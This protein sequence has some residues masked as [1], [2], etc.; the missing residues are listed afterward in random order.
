[1]ITR[2]QLASPPA[3]AVL[4]RGELA[5]A[6]PIRR[7][8]ASLAGTA[9]GDRDE[10]LRALA[11]LHDLMREVEQHGQQGCAKSRELADRPHRRPVRSRPCPVASSSSVSE[12]E[13]SL[14]TVIALNDASVAS[15]SMRL[16]QVGRQSRVGDDESQHRRHVGCHHAR[17]LGDPGQRHRHAMDRR[18]RHRTLGEGVG[19]HDRLGGGLDAIGP[20]AVGELGHARGDLLDRQPL[21]DHAGGGDEHLLGPAAQ[22]RWPSPRPRPAPPRRPRAPRNTLALPALTS[23][24]PRPAMRAGSRDTTGPGGRRWSSA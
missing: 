7:A 21:A 13:V 4:T 16:Q 2:P 11:V 17:A 9:H 24:R 5:I 15:R 8:E 22:R 14:S 19:G 10:L 6:S 20:Q 12:V 1:M 18:G 23:T 3:I